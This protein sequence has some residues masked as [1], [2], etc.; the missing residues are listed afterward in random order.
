[1]SSYPDYSHVCL[2]QY[3]ILDLTKYLIVLG[4]NNL[5]TWEDLTCEISP[6]PSSNR[7]TLI[8]D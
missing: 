7:I 8:M 2:L 3:D 4:G 6:A 5:I 1:M